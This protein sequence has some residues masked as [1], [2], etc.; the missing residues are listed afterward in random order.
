MKYILSQT[1]FTGFVLALY[2]VIE[3]L[4]KREMKYKENRLFVLVCVC[5]AI[6]SF[7]F[8]GVILQTE[9]E[10]AYLWRGIGMVGTFGYLIAAQYLIC[11]LSTFQKWYCRL[12]EIFSLLGIVLFFFVIQKEQTTYELS[13]IGMSYSFN[14]GIWNNLYITYSVIVAINQFLLI[15]HMMAA[16]KAQRFRELGKK[17]FVVEGIMVFGMMLDTIFPLFGQPAMPG[18]TIGQF[19]GLA[20]LY[21]SVS[22]LNH[23]RITISNM[24]EFIYYSLTIPVLVY[25]SEERLQIWN[26]TA[27][28]FFGLNKERMNETPIENLFELKKE[29]VFQFEGNSQNIDAVCFYNQKY[30]SLTVNKI[31]DSYGD[32]TGY[33]IIVTDLSERK[34]SMNRLEEAMKEAE[35]ANNAK[36]IFLAN[37]SHE[38]RTPMNAIIGFS[39]ILLKKDLGD[40][41]RAGVEDIKWSS[42][43]LLAIINDILDIS[44]IESGKMEIVPEQYYTANLLDDVALIIS[45]QAEKKNLR[46]E[47]KVDEKVPR[48]LYGDKVRIRGILINLLNNAVKYT[49]QGSITFEVRILSSSEEKIRLAYMVIDTGAGIK[50]ENLNT[51][52]DKFERLDQ[53]VH[54]GI[55]G[56]GLGLAIAKSYVGLM[57]GE[58]KVESRYGEGSVFTVEL[59]QDIIDNTPIE[60]EYLQVRDKSRS[61]R[62]REFKARNV[63]VL[64]VD[65]NPINLKVA[66]GILDAYDIAVDTALSGKEAIELCGKQ[67]YLLVFMD[68]MMPE[69]DGIQTMLQI[70]NLNE[71]YAPEGKAKMIVLT[72]NAIKGTREKLIGQG[73]DEYLGKPINIERLEGLLCRFIPEENIVYEDNKGM[74]QEGD[75]QDIMDYITKMLP[76]IDADLGLSYCGGQPEDYLKVLEITYKYGEHQLK[77]LLEL[78]EKQEYRTYSIKVHALKSASLNIGAADI[79][80]EAKRQEQAGLN[81]EI[82]Y[83]ENHISE[84]ISDYR[85][86]LQGIREILI[87]FDM[88]NLEIMSEK[89]MEYP[90]S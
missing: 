17:L 69:M 90:L 14:P 47:M 37:M 81:G 46:F 48:E 70:R 80:A 71:H 13:W 87:H 67:N 4:R 30:C 6:W 62:Q 76:G 21:H 86:V 54:H 33:I 38:I 55:E 1:I 57:G 34:K 39:E 10:Q 79:A 40:E 85:E 8:F 26:D 73:F 24:S 41:V 61:S 64:V 58:I 50:E 53:Q 22:F 20:V 82:A 65:D 2:F 43:N 5:S 42:H 88:L 31:H 9:P 15:I 49:S 84:L 44:K 63:R 68:Q 28:S 74:E 77:E 12:A 78:W 7:G 32:K 72:A 75:N 11:H 23:S 83:I 25:D 60:K 66:Q 16:S 29:T 35:Y 45:P 19:V 27:F 56:S 3:M 36:S 52:F 18:S 51:L 89:E 59:E